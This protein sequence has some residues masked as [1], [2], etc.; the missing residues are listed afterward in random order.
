MSEFD[1]PALPGP[2]LFE[3]RAAAEDP[4][5]RSEAGL[6][7]ATLL[8]RGTNGSDD[9]ELV[10][11][12]LN[13]TDEHGLD[14]VTEL[15]AHFPADSLPGALWR[16]YVLRAWV[17]REP[18]RAA[19]E[20]AAGKRFSP[21]DEVVAGVVDPPG[22]DEVA[23]LVDSVIRGIVTGDLSDILDRAAAFAR[24]VGIGRANLG[25]DPPNSTESAARLVETA[26]ALQNA[27]RHERLGSLR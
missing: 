26:T 7:V 5:V 18:A 3:S 13:L 15:W 11:R 4:A 23:H 14:L 24:V 16:L 8:V 22:P 12:V 25:E 6:R 27:A 2:G 20:F 21:V 9:R 19:R 10:D 17:R 1:K